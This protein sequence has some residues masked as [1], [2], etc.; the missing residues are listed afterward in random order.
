M[1][2]LLVGFDTYTGVK[3]PGIYVSRFDSGNSKWDAPPLAA[4]T[5]IS[6]YR[7]MHPNGRFLHAVGETPAGWANPAK[8]LTKVFVARP[9][10]HKL[11]ADERGAKNSPET[12]QCQTAIPHQ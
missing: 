12:A 6:R 2:E 8:K 10:S 3:S 9:Q 7:A 4:E 5:K 11:I 1:R